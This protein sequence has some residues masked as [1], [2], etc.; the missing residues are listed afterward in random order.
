MAM[1]K[2]QQIHNFN[3]FYLEMNY[4]QGFIYTED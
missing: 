1:E 4:V 3:F 2:H